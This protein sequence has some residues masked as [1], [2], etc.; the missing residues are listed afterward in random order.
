MLRLVKRN[1][2]AQ[3]QQMTRALVC[4]SHSLWA[5][6]SIAPPGQNLAESVTKRETFLVDLCDRFPKSLPELPKPKPRKFHNL[7]IQRKLVDASR[8][9]FVQERYQQFLDEVKERQQSAKPF[10]TRE[11]LHSGRW[12]II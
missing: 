1:F 4:D 2:I 10:I 6:H 5:K 11:S 7:L 8:L 3:A 12:K 9:Q